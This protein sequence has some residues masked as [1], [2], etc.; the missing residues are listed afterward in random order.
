MQCRVD[1]GMCSVRS[2]GVGMCS[3]V[4]CMCSVVW[5]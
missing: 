5:V 4:W 2:V 3:V 1:V